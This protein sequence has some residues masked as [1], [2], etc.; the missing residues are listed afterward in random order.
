MHPKET[1]YNAQLMH[2]LAQ[3][4]ASHLK[5]QT[6]L[7][8]S[9]KI[10]KQGWFKEDFYKMEMNVIDLI[11]QK[12]QKFK[13]SMHSSVASNKIKLIHEICRS[14]VEI[15]TSSSLMTSSH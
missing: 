10:E 6:Y 2:S 7:I 4:N 11:M 8:V 9:T 3:S 15:E 1:I 14:R 5:H 13:C 12:L